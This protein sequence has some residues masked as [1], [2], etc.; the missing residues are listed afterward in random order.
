MADLPVVSIR[1]EI[2]SAAAQ[3][4]ANILRGLSGAESLRSQVYQQSSQIAAQISFT[5]IHA[6][7]MA[8]AV[9]F[10]LYQSLASHEDGKRTLTDIS[11]RI[12][13]AMLSQ[14]SV[15]RN[16]PIYRTTD[17]TVR[18]QLLYH[19]SDKRLSSETA[20][21][22][23]DEP[24]ASGA[25]AQSIYISPSVT[26]AAVQNDPSLKGHHQTYK[27]GEFTTAD[28]GEA[29]LRI[30]II[31]ATI[32]AIDE[33]LEKHTYANLKNAAT[34][35][36][37][38]V[39]GVMSGARDI[40][41]LPANSATLIAAIGNE[42][43]NYAASAKLVHD[44]Q[45]Q[46]RDLANMIGVASDTIMNDVESLRNKMEIDANAAPDSNIA[47]SYA[48]VAQSKSLLTTIASEYKKLTGNDMRNPMNDANI[49]SDLADI[50]KAAK[51]N[52]LLDVTG[53]S[54]DTALNG[55]TAATLKEFLTRLQGIITAFDNVLKARNKIIDKTKGFNS[56]STKEMKA[57]SAAE[58]ALKNA[59]SALDAL[60]ATVPASLQSVVINMKAL[61]SDI[62]RTKAEIETYEKKRMEI[63]SA[64][65][66]PFTRAISG[67]AE[68][69]TLDELVSEV[70]KLVAAKATSDS[71]ATKATQEIT[72]HL[73]TIQ[74][75]NAEVARLKGVET[76]LTG[77]YS[78]L[79]SAHNTLKASASN[80]PVT[81]GATVVPV[82]PVVGVD[83]QYDPSSG[84][85]A[86]K[87]TG[88]DLSAIGSALGSI[89][90]VL[91]PALSTSAPPVAATKGKKIKKAGHMKVA[92]IAAAANK[93][94]SDA[95]DLSAKLSVATTEVAQLKTTAAQA[96]ADLKAAQD[97]LANA[98]ITTTTS[99]ADDQE[100][101]EL[102]QKVKT[103]TDRT[104]SL[105]K[106]LF[107]AQTAVGTLTQEAEAAAITISGLQS[108]ITSV[109]TTAD[110]SL[111]NAISRIRDAAHE[112][113][114]RSFPKNLSTETDLLI[115][116]SAKENAW[117]IAAV[118]AYIDAALNT[119]RRQTSEIATLKAKMGGVSSVDLS[120][121]RT[122]EEYNRLRQEAEELRLK[123]D[124][125]QRL[126]EEL[127]LASGKIDDLVKEKERFFADI[128]D[129]V[130]A[131]M[132]KKFK[133]LVLYLDTMKGFEAA[134][135][136]AIKDLE[137]QKLSLEHD[138]KLNANDIQTLQ[139]ALD[140]VNKQ[141]T[142]YYDALKGLA[143]N[144]ADHVVTIDE[145]TNDIASFYAATENAKVITDI[146]DRALALADVCDGELAHLIG[147]RQQLCK[148]FK[149]QV[150]F[151]SVLPEV[152]NDMKEHLDRFDVFSAKL[153]AAKTADDYGAVV[154]TKTTGLSSQEELAMCMG[155]W[156]KNGRK[157]MSERQTNASISYSPNAGRVGLVR[158]GMK[159]SAGQSPIRAVT[160]R[161]K[162]A[163]TGA[164]GSANLNAALDAAAPNLAPATAKNKST[165]DAG[166]LQKEVALAGLSFKSM[167]TA[168]P[169][170]EKYRTEAQDE[171]RMTDENMTS[172]AEYMYEII[173]YMSRLDK[174][175][176]SYGAVVGAQMASLAAQIGMKATIAIGTDTKSAVSAFNKIVSAMESVRD[177]GVENGDYRGSRVLT[178]AIYDI[179][180]VT[181]TNVKSEVSNALAY[182]KQ[183]AGLGAKS[184]QTLFYESSYRIFLRV[185]LNLYELDRGSGVI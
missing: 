170:T 76:Q 71:A 140:D 79:E 51:K 49:K 174:A 64:M 17:A 138:I 162:A 112:L 57:V 39:Q 44:L 62:P 147:T 31:G 105:E 94:S 109:N 98:T 108:T 136:T 134:Q 89:D 154:H 55:M 32:D 65:N 30:K 81:A 82:A 135:T 42:A 102:R 19:N 181:S 85:I 117:T 25:L 127:Q 63:I 40:T 106:D 165:L 59:V 36:R 177:T 141:M 130:P 58:T 126:Q 92:D 83:F 131:D 80:A 122:V 156:E 150:T 113:A 169:S 68:S 132:P 180:Y 9:A 123:V 163:K 16:T 114:L 148:L 20:S 2:A 12:L 168:P 172:H 179:V 161:S 164:A 8:D 104:T 175:D 34:A 118:D 72:A 74:L 107:T 97:A 115:N 124:A 87:A 158:S 171:A 116:D 99:V 184:F 53:T 11:D 91:N 1:R 160:T 128:A 173:S 4:A 133:D 90:A 5:P 24:R 86:Y 14:K 125:A 95:A 23:I 45:T 29:K 18:A 35:H 60:T 26:A 52:M 142:E 46:R 146:N 21:S 47:T 143:I 120:A 78:T 176:P 137:R 27:T 28:S 129:K 67:A 15:Y 43:S 167:I 103:L 54:T 151:L 139:V 183:F 33:A 69:P 10:N 182:D 101:I 77:A 7:D 96:A 119:I 38:L 159:A 13:D 111:L 152:Q 166:Q 153:S 3:I 185:L 110:G 73:A 100:K 22:W 84:I 145:F 75:Q 178:D 157:L 66:L 144:M 155:A 41:L 61:A 121:Y 93:L 70:S 88:E 48:I 50:E 149:D 6:G 56:S 37:T